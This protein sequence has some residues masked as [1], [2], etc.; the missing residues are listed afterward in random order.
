MKGKDVE[1]QRKA[2]VKN[3]PEIRVVLSTGG[4]G[5]MKITMELN[6]SKRMR[7]FLKNK[8]QK[9]KNKTKER[10]KKKGF[11]ERIK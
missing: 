9:R 1:R 6:T 10:E 7:V 3:Y 2:D 8:R 4:V 5:E 11:Q